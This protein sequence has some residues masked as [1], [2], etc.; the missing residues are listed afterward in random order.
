MSD[1]R[2]GF[3]ER[4]RRRWGLRAP[5]VDPKRIIRVDDETLESR[6][7]QAIAAVDADVSEVEL[8][9]AEAVVTLE[10]SVKTE[11]ARREVV[12]ACDALAGVHGVDDRL[13]IDVDR[14]DDDAPC[15]ADRAAGSD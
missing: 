9:V 2:P 10:G 7:K 15:D 13:E 8:E 3:F 1:R 4:L 11:W 5:D 14:D 6:V 12:R